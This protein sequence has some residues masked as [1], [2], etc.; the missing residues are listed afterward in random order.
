MLKVEDRQDRFR[1]SAASSWLAQRA[2]DSLLLDYEEGGL[3]SPILTSHRLSDLGHGLEGVVNLS[4]GGQI[5]RQP[6]DFVKEAVR[7]AVD[8]G[9]FHYPGVRG[10]EDFR[11]TLSEKLAR[12]N[13]ITADPA[14]EILPTI[15]A[16]FAID[17]TMRILVNPGDEVLL[18][19]PDYACFEPLI[20]TYGGK[21]ISVPL[22]DTPGGWVFDPDDVR[23]RATP[24][25]KLF[26]FS[27]GNNPTGYLYTRE[28]LEAIADVARDRDFFVF[29]DEEYE[30]LVFDGKP[31]LSIASL[32]GMAERTITAFSFSKAYSLSGMRIGYAVGP[33]KIMDH[34]YNVIRLSIQAVGSLS[35]RAAMAVL[36]GPTDAW[37]RE[38]VL[39]LERDRDFAVERLN[40]MPKVR[41]HRP[42]ACYFLF[43]RLEVGLPSWELAE[44]LLKEARISVISGHN[45][46]RSGRNYLRISGC[47]GRQRLVEGLNRMEQALERLASP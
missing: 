20:R 42:V 27:C 46:G 4:A 13:K 33:A 26:C 43:P 29:S 3:A 11:L 1:I 17:A 44:Y 19:E 23:R 25:T 12:E 38:V 6:P 34:M 18:I 41:V 31:H 2:R 15:G 8:D 30:K 22:R 32:P 16:E 5:H 45:F 28:D 35:Q 7:Q 39:D 24:C 40:S 14:T 9:R 47:V 36:K 10:D 37:L 21:P